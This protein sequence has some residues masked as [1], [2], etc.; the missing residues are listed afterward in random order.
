MIDIEKKLVSR[1][2]II[3]L[4]IFS[5]ILS[6]LLVRP[7]LT[8]ILTS[9]VL[10][11][12]FMPVYEWI[13]SKIGHKQISAFVVT[14]LILLIFVVP[15]L[16]LLVQVASQTEVVY[17]TLKQIIAQGGSVSDCVTDDVLCNMNQKIFS[18]IDTPSL[19]LY[20]Q[21][22]FEKITNSFSEQIVDFVYSVPKRLF[23]MLLIF[24]MTF[25]MLMDGK[26]FLKN[27]ERALPLKK[28]DKTI[29]LKKMHSMTHAII[30]GF[31]LMAIVE[32]ILGMIVFA[33][34]GIESYIF[35]G[36]VIGFF[37]LIPLIG[38]TII[39]IPALLFQVLQGDV[40]ASIV[41]LLGGGIISFI[42]TFIK[43]KMIGDK[44]AVH[45]ILMII[46][47]VGGIKLLGVIGFIFGPLI[48]TLLMTFFNMYQKLND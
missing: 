19:K 29:I 25:F 4:L 45:P 22:S 21:D 23:D 31:F 39:Y 48:L 13:K 42:D 44:S 9:I 15:M 6:I 7:Y 36:L 32:G 20:V 47:L 28:K 3:G 16:F 2:F 33:I 37:A 11:Y 43:P 12:I 26:D 46:G 38:P 24:F 40:Y 14:F 1:Y 41:L 18:Y 10:A 5:I 17:I 30:H 34:A 35:W 27:L 8:P